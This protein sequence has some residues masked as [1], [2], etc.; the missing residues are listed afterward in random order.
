MLGSIITN[1][2]MTWYT[3]SMFLPGLTWLT[4]DNDA[5]DTDSIWYISCVS[6]SN[7][8]VNLMMLWF[9]WEHLGVLDWY[10]VMPIMWLS[11]LTYHLPKGET[12]W[13]GKSNFCNTYIAY[14][15]KYGGTWT[16]SSW[17]DPIWLSE[18][19]EHVIEASWGL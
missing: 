19:Q 9:T 11:T 4:E 3:S 12:A 2:S 1:N 16:V 5:R 14:S 13:I 15:Q 7:T 8:W 6:W 18:E 10:F 17:W